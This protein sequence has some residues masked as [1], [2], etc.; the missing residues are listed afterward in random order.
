MTC[1]TGQ[2]TTKTPKKKRFFPYRT[3]GHPKHPDGAKGSG[4]KPDTH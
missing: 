4:K 1:V 2:E 3:R